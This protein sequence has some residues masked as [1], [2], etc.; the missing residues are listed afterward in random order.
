M[1]SH[2]QVP[3]PQEESTDC[4]YVKELEN[5]LLESH[6]EARRH[7]KRNRQQ[8]KKEYDNT[9]QETKFAA[10]QWVWLFNPIR[11]KRRS[12]KLQIGWE[13]KTHKI[14]D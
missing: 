2:L 13:E 6:E 8:A 3:V 7:L 1:H 12:P 10:N 9:A 4:D 5:K 14:S 11:K